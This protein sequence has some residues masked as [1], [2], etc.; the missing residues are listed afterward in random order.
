MVPGTYQLTIS[1]PGYAPQSWSIAV[2]PGMNAQGQ[3]LYLE[4]SNIPVPEFNGLIVAAVSALA[5]SLYVLRRRR[6]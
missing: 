6:N 2:T 4:Q 5:A 1:S 3:N